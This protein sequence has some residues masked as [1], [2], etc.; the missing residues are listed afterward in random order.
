MIQPA[1]QQDKEVEGARAHVRG[2][3]SLELAEPLEALLTYHGVEVLHLWIQC[4]AAE[5]LA[6]LAHVI[7]V[8]EL[9]HCAHNENPIVMSKL[10]L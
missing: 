5:L 2:G 10:L 8:V 6:E 9:F 1:D 7:P 3:E 4:G